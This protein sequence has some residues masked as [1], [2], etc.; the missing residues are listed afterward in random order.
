[1]TKKM[2]PE[3]QALHEK[4]FLTGDALLKTPAT[5]EAVKVAFSVAPMA[6]ALQHTLEGLISEN[7][8]LSDTFS[9]MFMTY[10]VGEMAKLDVSIIT[11]EDVEDDA[12][13]V[14]EAVIKVATNAADIISQFSEEKALENSAYAGIANTLMKYYK[15]IREDLEGN[16]IELVGN[17]AVAI[18]TLFLSDEIEEL[19]NKIQE[20]EA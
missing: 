13:G 9:L 5:E 8:N 19:V 12:E 14:A 10:A 1:M 15:A 3:I 2:T 4:V 17:L 11:K 6:V 18:A 7:E 20:I 16:Q